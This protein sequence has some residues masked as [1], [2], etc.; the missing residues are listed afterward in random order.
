[1]TT[2]LTGADLASYLDAPESAALVSI[3]QRS[4]ALVTQEWANPTTPVP[5]WVINIAWDVALRAGVNPKQVTSQTRSW[6]DITKTERW[7]AG[8]SGV[9]LTD[10][11]KILLNG[12]AGGV[13]KSVA[14]GSIRLRIPGWDDS[15]GS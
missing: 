2:F 4:N 1:M 5:A 7:E 3:A 9:R 15:W 13:A 14:A 6:D 12:S 11:E 8:T 10:A